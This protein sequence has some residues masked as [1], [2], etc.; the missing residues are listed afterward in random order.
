M[1]MKIKFGWRD[2]PIGVIAVCD[3]DVLDSNGLSPISCL[4][5]DD[6]GLDV[7]AS[8][9]WIREGISRI[10]NALAG[11][12]ELRLTWDREDWGAEF[13]N[14]YTTIYS[15]YDEQVSEKVLTSDFR[16]V[17][18]DW[19]KFIEEDNKSREFEIELFSWNSDKAK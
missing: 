4:L 13:T 10:D 8:L 14:F 2:T 16:R 15:H 7:P 9:A 1:V 18:V 12:S 19:L 11:S 17:L 6:G 5:M 3:S